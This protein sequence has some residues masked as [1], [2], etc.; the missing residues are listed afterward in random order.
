MWECILCAGRKAAFDE[1]SRPYTSV[2]VYEV[3]A[4]TATCAT[5]HG[6]RAQNSALHPPRAG[7]RRGESTVC[8]LGTAT[9]VTTATHVRISKME[10]QAPMSCAPCQRPRRCSYSILPA[11]YG[12]TCNRLCHTRCTG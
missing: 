8:G 5:T 6:G 4:S 7:A 12:N 3:K 11:I 1:S 2:S 9:L 10:Y